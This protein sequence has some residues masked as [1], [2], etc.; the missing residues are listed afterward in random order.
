MPPV[1]FSGKCTF[2]SGPGH[3]PAPQPLH[4]PR[5]DPGNPRQ[6]VEAEEPAHAAGL[7]DSPGPHGPNCGK[8][9]EGTFTHRVDLQGQAEEQSQRAQG[10]SIVG[11][12]L[13]APDFQ[14]GD[15][16]SPERRGKLASPRIEGTPPGAASQGHCQ[17]PHHEPHRQSGVGLSR[18]L[19]PGQVLGLVGASSTRAAC[20]ARTARSACSSSITTEILISLVLIIWILMS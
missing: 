6:G 2:W 15:R 14:G 10:R 11:G 5:T 4:G 17:A 13:A 3:G 19:A 20:R 18:V 1:P 9:L 7:D 12:S 8:A 16:R